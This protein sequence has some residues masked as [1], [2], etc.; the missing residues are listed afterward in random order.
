[1]A[2]EGA[3]V[4]FGGDASELVEAARKAAEAVKGSVE[5]MHESLEGLNEKFE[6]VTKGFVAFSAAVEGGEALKEF[7]ET[8]VEV[9]MGALSLGR[10]LG[11]STT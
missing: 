3:N 10:A 6:L 8:T 11:I 5:K 9:A 7:V 2:E 4:H 1:M